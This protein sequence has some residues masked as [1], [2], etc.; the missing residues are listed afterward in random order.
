MR[1]QCGL[2]AKRHIHMTPDEALALHVKD[3]D[4][5]FVLTKSYGRALIYAD[6]VVEYIEVIIWQCTLIR[7]KPMLL[8]A[9]RNL[10]V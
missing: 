10:M 5:V 3:N 1:P 7:M 8:T 4:E 6:V 9:I 2:V